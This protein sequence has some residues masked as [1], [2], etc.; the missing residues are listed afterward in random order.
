M[1]HLASVWGTPKHET[2]Y[3]YYSYNSYPIQNNA[4]DKVHNYIISIIILDKFPESLRQDS[5]VFNNETILLIVCSCISTQHL[6][7]P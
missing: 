3:C 7:F 5:C 4:A 1:A 6:Y 2:S